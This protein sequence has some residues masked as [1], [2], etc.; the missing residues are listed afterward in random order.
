MAGAGNDESTRWRSV[1]G[2]VLPYG[3][4]TVTD[5]DVAA[6]TKVLQSD[7]LTQGPNVA[8]FE[9]QV[10]EH[11]GAKHAVAVSNGTAA[12]HLAM[13]SLGLKSG[14]RLWTSPN[15]FVASANCGRYCGADVDFVDIDPRT[16]NLSVDALGEKLEAADKAGPLPT[17]VVPVHFAG[18]P[19]QMSEIGKLADRYGFG[20]VEDAAHA[21]GAEYSGSRIGDCAFS[22]LT[23][24]SFHPVKTNLTVPGTTNRSS[25]GGIIGSPIFNAHWDRPKL[26]ACPT[27]SRSG[28]RSPAA[29]MNCWQICRSS[30]RGNIQ[31][32]VLHGISM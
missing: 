31:M 25:L 14:D 30:A 20:V 5:A 7:W 13:Q 19:C 12:L 22:S 8:E 28:A 24:F 17:V 3:R 21:V 16:Y 15:T 11:C 10:A 4:Q 29:T 23:T 9:R 18:Q 2:S 1:P 32:H 6:V 27:S 26:G